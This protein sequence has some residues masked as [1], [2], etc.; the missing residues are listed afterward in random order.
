MSVF[1]RYTLCFLTRADQV[2]L[3][4]R[5]NPP[6]AGLWNGVGGHIEPGE[7]PRQGMLREIT[8]ETGYPVTEVDFRGVL[9]W[10]GFEIQDGGLYIFTAAVDRLTPP[11]ELPASEG[12]LA[13]QPREWLLS[14][15]KVVENIHYFAPYMLT[16]GPAL[17]FHFDYHGHTILS[18]AVQPLPGW[19]DID[20]IFQ[21]PDV[22]HEK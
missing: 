13:W 21:P 17:H 4:L 12:R 3:L 19:V 5:S 2:L 20:R 18:H 1:P 9:T 22:I 10:N 14:G 15:T 11:A 6:N 8:E 16:P 7:T